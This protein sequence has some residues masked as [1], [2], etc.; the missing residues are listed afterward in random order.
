MAVDT[1][2]DYLMG[3]YDGYFAALD[4]AGH[5]RVYLGA[6]AALSGGLFAVA[7]WLLYFWSE[8]SD[9][10]L[11]TVREAA[12]ASGALGLALVPLGA[13]LL[14]TADA[15]AGGSAVRRTTTAAV[16]C[17][18]AGLATFVYAYPSEWNVT[19][20]DYSLLGVTLFGVG[21]GGL[22]LAAGA[23]VGRRLGRSAWRWA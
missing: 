10:T 14:L 21:L 13:V 18:L 3:W 11:W 16:G 5:R 2:E 23:A 19:G 20:F 6:Y 12:F 4:E 22:F 17:C 8:A 1:S 15:G 9:A 7:G